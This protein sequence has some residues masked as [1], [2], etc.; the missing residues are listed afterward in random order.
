[1]EAITP[2]EL[3]KLLQSENPP[4]LLDV[5]QPEEFAHAALPGATLVPLDTLPARLEE[6]AEWRDQKVVVY[7]HH[8]MRSAHAI[9]WLSGQGFNKLVNLSG[10]IDRWSLDVDP[11]VPRY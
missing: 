7:C 5:R 1:M 6:L 9:G 4:H 3:A 2:A 8:G 10:G 11:A